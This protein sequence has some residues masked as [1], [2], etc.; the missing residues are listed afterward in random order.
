MSTH[1]KKLIARLI[2]TLGTFVLLIFSFLQSQISPSLFRLIVFFVIMLVFAFFLI[3][4]I[5]NTKLL[6]FLVEAELKG[7][8]LES[9]HL[10]STPIVFIGLFIIICKNLY[11]IQPSSFLVKESPSSIE[12]LLF[13]LDQ[14]IRSIGLDFL[15]TFKFHISKIDTDSSVIMGFIFTYKT[16]LAFT[17][18]TFIFKTYKLIKHNSAAKK[19]ND[20]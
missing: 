17:F 10:L 3:K 9:F 1:Q 4:Q 13:G 12:W 8:R 7:N 6:S 19:M 2:L 16:L 11:L 18:W 15:E 20:F 14:T 5:R